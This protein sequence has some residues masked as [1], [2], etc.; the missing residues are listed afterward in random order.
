MFDVAVGVLEQLGHLR[1]AGATHGHDPVDQLAVELLG[2]LAAGRSQ[3]ANDLG[4]RPEPEGLVARVDPLG[5]VGESEVLAGPQ[6]RALFEEWAHDLLRR[7]GI[8]GGLEHDEHAWL[9]VVADLL[10]R[11]D[12]GSEFRSAVVAEGRRHAS[13]DGSSALQGDGVP[14][15][16]EAASSR[17]TTFS[18]VRSVTGTGRP[19]A[20]RSGGVAVEADHGQPAAHGLLDHRQADVAETDDGEVMASAGTRGSDRRGGASRTAATVSA[21]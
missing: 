4:G 2:G 3:P 7:A 10:H 17:A 9:K 1:L 8:G 11:R 15:D 13:H 6:A 19:A 18:S 21:H 12:D 20:R 5:G 16:V 14:G